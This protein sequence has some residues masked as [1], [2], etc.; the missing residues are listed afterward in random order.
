MAATHMIQYEDMTGRR[1]GRLVVTGLSPYRTK[2]GKILWIAKCDCGGEKITQPSNLRCGDTQSCGC[3][4]RELMVARNFIHG[5][6]RSPEFRSWAAMLSRCTN[7][8]LREY[9]QYGGRGIAVCDR[10]REFAN[11]LTD[12]GRRPTAKHTL[13][14]LNVNG[15]YEPDNCSWATQAEQLRNMR[16]NIYVEINGQ[17]MCVADA[18]KI[19]GI[20]L[21]SVYSRIRKL[22]WDPQA[23]IDAPRRGK[24]N[25]HC[26]K[27]H[28]YDVTDK[29]GYRRCGACKRAAAN[30]R[31]HARKA[32]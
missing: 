31:Y 6:S 11:F 30:A 7:E 21:P 23:A 16:R 9:P 8:R 18:A 13:E 25:S 24:N 19:R 3:I 5:E 12:M 14:R 17:M 2:S 4:K 22:G 28:P 15:N 10:W 27:G 29:N 32:A 1:F 26:P 20:P